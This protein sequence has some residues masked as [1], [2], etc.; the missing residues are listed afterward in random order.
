MFFDNVTPGWAPESS[1]WVCGTSNVGTNGITEFIGSTVPTTDSGRDWAAHWISHEIG[2]NLGLYHAAVGSAN[3]MNPTKRV[4]EQLTPDQID[5]VFQ[6]NFHSD[7]VGYTPQ[8]GTGFPQPITQPVLGDYN[9]DGAVNAADYTL[10]RATLG[11]TA[12]AAADGNTNGKID[13]GDFSI[14]QS[15]FDVNSQFPNLT[16]DFNRDGRV[17]VA[18][19]MVW[20]TTLGTSVP[21]GTGADANMNG[22]IDSG[23]YAMWQSNFGANAPSTGVPGDFNRDGVVDAADYTI[24]RVTS[25]TPVAI[26]TGADANRNGW[27]DPGDYAIWQA[28]IGATHAS[29]AG[30]AAI[31]VPEPTTLLLAVVA[32]A[33]LATRRCRRRQPRSTRPGDGRAAL[34]RGLRGRSSDEARSQ[35]GGRRRRSTA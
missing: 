12:V 21:V 27:V 19:Y 4:S 16:G 15:R 25:G 17:D 18:D 14:W 34:R 20:R 2:H 31:D 13:P 24:W 28:N 22:L 9:R 11:S 6:L 8:G 32:A 3:L 35:P 26:G 5:S 23:D 10:W 7:T 1:N 30:S 33:P 29:S